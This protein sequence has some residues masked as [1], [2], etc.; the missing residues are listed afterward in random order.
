MV[1]AVTLLAQTEEWLD[2]QYCS[3]SNPYVCITSKWRG[4]HTF[5]VELRD[6]LWNIFGLNVMYS[7]TL[8]VNLPRS[9]A[10]RMSADSFS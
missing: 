7:A 8:A 5:A 3:G 1:F 2:V 4:N 10:A 9:T 6:P